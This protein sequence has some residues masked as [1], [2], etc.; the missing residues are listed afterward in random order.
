MHVVAYLNHKTLASFCSWAGWFDSYLV[1]QP[2][3]RFSHVFPLSQQA[4]DTRRVKG[5][6]PTLDREEFVN[7]YNLLTERPEI[8]E[9]FL[10]YVYDVKIHSQV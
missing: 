3:D 6:K 7:F 1:T 2:E 4:A 10:K 5:E 9:L 8:E